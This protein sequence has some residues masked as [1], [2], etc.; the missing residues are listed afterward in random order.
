MVLV[1]VGVSGFWRYGVGVGGVGVFWRSRETST[2]KVRARSSRML[3]W[4]LATRFVSNGPGGAYAGGLLGVK[5]M[6]PT[7]R[8]CARLMGWIGHL[9][10]G[11]F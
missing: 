8:S 7:M 5:S 2:L 4:A 10:W 1:L 9:R 3:Q 11:F 6:G